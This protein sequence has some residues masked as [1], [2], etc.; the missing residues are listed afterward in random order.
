MSL[1][2]LLLL[3]SI[4][5]ATSSLPASGHPVFDRQRV[6][7]ERLS[8]YTLNLEQYAELRRDFC[9][10][11]AHETF[12]EFKYSRKGVP[13]RQV[14]MSLVPPREADGYSTTSYRFDTTLDALGDRTHIRREILPLYYVPFA[15]S[16]KPVEIRASNAR[17]VQ[18]RL[19]LSDL[20]PTHNTQYFVGRDHG[21]L[22]FRRS[23]LEWCFGFGLTRH[24]PHD[25]F[26]KERDLG[27]G[28][29][30]CEG[31]MGFP[32]AGRGTFVAIIDSA[33]IMRSIVFSVTKH[34][35]DW[36]IYTVKTSS[37]QFPVGTETVAKRGVYE[38]EI[39]R[40]GGGGI[41]APKMDIDD[42]F[43]ARLESLTQGLTTNDFLSRATFQE[44]PEG[45]DIQDLS[46][47][48]IPLPSITSPSK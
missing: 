14:D 37:G 38:R 45:T 43:S 39:V 26:I 32:I 30:E 10:E 46:N 6:R 42:G 15:F 35:S 34:S 23:I 33:N 3:L 29:T 27:N 11:I 7:D 20:S 1:R 28:L 5:L 31:P 22:T 12:Q 19:T 13:R 18:E 41:Q 16:G 48:R 17:G 25:A 9:A 47:E 8:S 4:P 36:H 44:L 2:T 24:V 21:E 40:R